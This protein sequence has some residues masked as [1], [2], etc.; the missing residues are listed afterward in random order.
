MSR[1]PRAVGVIGC[2][3]IGSIRAAVAAADSGSRLVA[4]ADVDATRA[5]D[6]AR[7]EGVTASPSWEALVERADIDIV[8]VATTHDQLAAIS[9]AAVHSGKHVLCE[10]PMSTTAAAAAEVLAAAGRAGRVVAVGFNHRYHPAVLRAR[11]SVVTGELGSLSFIRCR[12]GHGG[13]PGYER[14]WRLDPSRSGGGEL[15]DQGIHAID[16]FRWFLGELTEVT[17]FVATYGWQAPVEDN[18]FALFRASAGQV[19]S[20]H[21]SWTQWKNLFSFEVF[22]ERGAAIV[23]GLGGS[24]GPETLTLYRRAEHG[25]PPHEE[26]IAFGGPDQSWA[27]EWSDFLR[28]VDGGPS[29]GADAA[30][31]VAALAL[32]EA[33]YA[34]SR[35]SHGVA[36]GPIRSG[37]GVA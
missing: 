14:E 2:G 34:A 3:K 5:A 31:G 27:A 19:A 25:G 30:D 16:L 20:L 28:A 9:L 33:V 10:K 4:V 17:G 1:S 8:V 15:L 7:R 23:T 12:Y 13:R 36:V 32:V 26:Q 24:Y 11:Q 6:L 37:T 29:L 35:Q 22:G 21:A 18:A